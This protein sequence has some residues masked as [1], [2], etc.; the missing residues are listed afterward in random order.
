MAEEID[1]LPQG[2]AIEE[3]AT[4]DLPEGWSVVEP[5]AE[6]KE[7]GMLEKGARVLGQ[8][9]LG[10]IEGSP[11]G[12][13]YDIGVGPAGSK[14]FN[15]LN[16]RLRIGEDIEFLYEKNAGK[17]I[18]EWPQQDQDLYNSLA[19]QIKPGAQP[20]NV[21]EGV[22][23]SIRSLAEKATGQDLKPQG[24]AEKAANWI[25]FIKDPKKLFELGKTGLN[26]K[27]AITAIAPSGREVLRGIGAG[28][29]LQ[30]AEEG[31]FGPIGIMASAV[32]GDIGGNLASSG[33]K[34]IKNLVTKPREVLAEVASKFTKK[35]KLDLQKDIIK[36]FR[37]AGIQADIGTITN[38]DLMKWTQSRLAQ[39]GLTGKALDELKD[40]VTNQ[41]KEEYKGLADSIGEARFASSHEAGVVAKDYIKQIRDAD[42]KD[43]R[44]LY[45]NAENA[46]KEGSSVESKRISQEIKR[47]EDALKP[48]NL[49][50]S[51][52]SAV[53]DILTKIK[54]DIQDSEGNLLYAKVKDLM[55]NKTA[56][57]DIINYEV[58]GGT[59]QLLKGLVSEI[60][61]AI[62]S[63]GKENPTF[64]KNYILANKKFSQ[65]AKT[66]RNKRVAQLLT[67]NDPAQLLNK[68]NSVQGIQD[69][70]KILSKSSIGSEVM[71]SLKRFKLD[72][73][74]GDNLVD[75]T[76][77]QIKFGTFSKLLEKGKNRDIA[78]EILP[79]QAYKRLER[80]QKNSGRLAEAAQKFFNSSKSG[81]TIEDVAIVGKF[82]SDLGNALVGNPWPLFKTAGGI[83]GAR[84]ITKL[85]ADPSFLKLV[86]DMILASEQNNISLMSSIGKEMISPIKAAVAQE[87]RN[88]NRDSN[89]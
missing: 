69:L 35:D 19:E 53:L 79:K 45:K 33:A 3:P 58:Q 86:E 5:Q 23:L 54:R 75:S 8:F 64:A 6:K 38:S 85:M 72:K 28:T 40:T 84:Y 78:K 65:H 41:I 11:A 61:R 73:M 77:Q 12:L 74:I 46:L 87:A 80:L 27:D 49:K 31:D 59:K 55:N 20:T 70:E 76:T 9:G 1:E 34:G 50:S 48:G 14:A 42:L 15:T 62:V 71:N 82:L 56:L 63:H 51:E 47:I 88:T 60:D 81:A 36:D 17:S 30:L 24:I 67:D 32:V 39:S 13:V 66:F 83:T 26:A 18:E 22:D 29:A 57:N 52:Q 37:D 10:L 68:M 89:R 43:V 16:E 25:G 7:P 21:S 2:W 44:G 4:Q